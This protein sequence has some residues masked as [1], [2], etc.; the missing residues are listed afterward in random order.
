MTK[1]V[2]L[3]VPLLAALP[4][5]LAAGALRR[6]P[7]PAGLAFFPEP[8]ALAPELAVPASGPAGLLDRLG[9]ARVLVGHASVDLR[10][11]V[12]PERE[13]LVPARVTMFESKRS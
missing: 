3:L 11:L 12:G 5:F 6:P 9:G 10:I 1:K 8:I 7:G 2:L 4:L 13:A